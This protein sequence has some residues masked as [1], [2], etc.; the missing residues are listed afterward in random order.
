ME[1][2]KKLGTWFWGLKRRYKVLLVIW[3]LLA[4]MMEIDVQM[5]PE[6]EKQGY[7][8]AENYEEA[9]KGGFDSR[10]DYEAA[11]AAGFSTLSEWDAYKAEQRKADNQAKAEAAKEKYGCMP[12][13]LVE[14]TC[15]YD[16]NRERRTQHYCFAIS[17]KDAEDRVKSSCENSMFHRRGGG[18]TIHSVRDFYL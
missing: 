14:Y 15:D 10:Y 3:A 11:A 6:W 16:P 5:T 18:A 9:V 8:S 2:L 13:V 1:F 12:T 17:P 7:Q 4:V